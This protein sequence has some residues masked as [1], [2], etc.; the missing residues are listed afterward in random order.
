M[1]AVRHVHCLVDMEVGRSVE[2]LLSG[3][4]IGRYTNT[5]PPNKPVKRGQLISPFGV[6]ALVDFRGDESLMTAGLDEWP[7]AYEECPQD[8]LVREER[9]QARLGVSHFRLPPDFRDPGRGVQYAN[10]HIPF[11][12]FPRWHYC[13]RRGIM[14]KLPIFGSR[15]KCPC[16]LDLDC[17]SMPQSRRPWLIPSRFIAACSKGHIEDFPF[18]EWI[19]RGSA[20]D[21]QHSLRLLPGRSSASLSGIRVDCGCGKSGTMAGTFNP[22]ALHGIGY[23]CSGSMPWLGD[24]GDG[25][26]H[27]GEHLRVIQRGASNVYFPLSTFPYGEKTQ[28]VLSTRF[29]TNQSRGPFSQQDWMMEGTFNR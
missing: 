19:H 9:L 16:R 12:R 21:D 15:V 7:F 26:G 22:E 24:D 20:W 2:Q 17:H 8:W 27:C 13:P 10:Q 5:M 6:G 1:Q 14:E 4:T 11:V 25:P 3:S 23:D 29:L 18:M 28:D